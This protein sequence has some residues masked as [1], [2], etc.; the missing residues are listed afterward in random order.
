MSNATQAAVV[1]IARPNIISQRGQSV[2]SAVSSAMPSGAP[3]RLVAAHSR[4]HAGTLTI[5]ANK[6]VNSQP[7]T[8]KKAQAVQPAATR[9]GAS[10]PARTPKAWA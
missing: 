6:L 5:S 7:I 2:G 4:R 10:R 3:A 8:M 9:H 1:V